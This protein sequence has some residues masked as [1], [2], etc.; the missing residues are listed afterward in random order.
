M[1]KSTDWSLGSLNR[2]LFPAGSTLHCC[3]DNL[4][5]MIRAMMDLSFMVTTVAVAV[6]ESPWYLTVRIYINEGFVPR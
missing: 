3:S 5:I 2:F 4:H 6:M 1:H